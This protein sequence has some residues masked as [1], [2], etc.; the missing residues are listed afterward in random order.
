[1]LWADVQARFFMQ[2]WVVWEPSCTDVTKP[3]SVLNYF[4]GRT[5]TNL[6]TV[7]RSVSSDPPVQHNH[8]TFTLSVVLICGRVRASV[9]V[10]WVRKQTLPPER[11]PKLVPTFAD[12]GCS[13]V[14][15]TDP[16]G[17]ILGF[18]DWSC[19]FFFQAAPQLYDEAEW[20]PFQT[21]WFSEN[22]ETPGIEPGSLVQ[23]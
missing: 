22:L 9:F 8:V 15:A 7:S 20:T 2:H 1:M 19:Y 12:R 23:R 18:L 4:I 21:H 3:K 10:T 5:V 17:R 16:H 6:Q 11:T 14:S 13:V